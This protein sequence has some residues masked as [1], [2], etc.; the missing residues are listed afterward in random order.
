MPV[1]EGWE[2]TSEGEATRCG[3]RKL[4][5]A[6]L[7]MA[8]REEAAGAPDPACVPMV[9]L[10]EATDNSDPMRGLA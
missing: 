5:L 3:D 10:R 1:E 7:H 6:C 4:D 2:S 8:W 9:M